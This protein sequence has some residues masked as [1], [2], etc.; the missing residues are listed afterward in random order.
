MPLDE[1]YLTHGSASP[2][3]PGTKIQ[4]AW[5]KE[6]VEWLYDNAIQ[7]GDCLICHLAPNA[8]GYCPISFGREIKARAHRIVFFVH[9]PNEDPEKMVLHKCDRRD[10]ININ[11]LF[12]GTAQ[13]NT[14]DM[15]SKGRKVDDPEVAHRK[16]LATAKIIAT[17][18]QEGMSNVEISRSTGLSESTIGNYVSGIYRDYLSLFTGD[19]DSVCV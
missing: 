18:R 1:S 11:H 13:D 10:C 14:D 7:D 17:Y 5:A 15:V 3:L 6:K 4:Y 19:Q 9:N 16:K 2:F 12:A 8:K